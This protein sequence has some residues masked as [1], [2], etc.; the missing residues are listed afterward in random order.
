MYKKHKIVMLFTNEKS[1]IHCLEKP[2]TSL[3][4]EKCSLYVLSNDEIKEND[5]PCWAV[6]NN[7]D[8]VY[9][10]Q[11]LEGSKN[12]K[13]IIATTKIRL[14]TSEYSERYRE[15]Y[16]NPLPNISQSFI[17]YFVSDYNRGNITT[18]VIVEYE[19]CAAGM[20][21]VNNMTC[22][23]SG[24]E[25]PSLKINS[26]NTINIKPFKDSWNREEI[27]ELF[28]KYLQYLTNKNSNLELSGKQW[29]EENL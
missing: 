29:I 14:G 4:V 17:E 15:S 7:L 21:K 20:C 1:N 22:G 2:S 19:E 28:E 11:T 3:T 25:K 12:W 10:V 23:H 16:F 24:C 6:N 9:Q 8:T 5:L 18:E 13:K 27:F 26:D